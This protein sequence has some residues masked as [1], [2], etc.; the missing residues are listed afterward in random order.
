M[1]HGQRRKAS[2]GQLQWSL[3]INYNRAIWLIDRFVAMGI[4]E[5]GDGPQPRRV[6][7]DIPLFIRGGIFLSSGDKELI[8]RGVECIQRNNRCTKK[9][10]SE[11][12][13]PGD[14]SRFVLS[15]EYL[16]ATF[17]E[18]KQS[19]SYQSGTFAIHRADRNRIQFVVSYLELIGVLGRVDHL[20]T[21]S[22]EVLVDLKT[23]RLPFSDHVQNLASIPASTNSLA[24]GE[25][26]VPS[27]PS[28]P[29]TETHFTSKQLLSLACCSVMCCGPLIAVPVIALT[30]RERARGNRNYQ[31]FS[32]LV[33]A[34]LATI[35]YVALAILP[36]LDPK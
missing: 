9:E 34:Y 25:A 17:E 7:I 8:S 1:I 30:H 15:E 26:D 16:H 27:L 11:Y 18:M 29:S 2:A 20:N 6:L 10:L 36:A 4:I 24:T 35:T 14:L 28:T 31:T 32:A 33:I 3:D 22:I 19:Y 23:Y 21:E 12:L 5:S 13:D